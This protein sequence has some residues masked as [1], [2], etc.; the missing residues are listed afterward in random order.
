MVEECAVNE[1]GR[2]MCGA[3]RVLD[4]RA[5]I[6]E[7]A[8]DVVQK[9]RILDISSEIPN[10]TMSFAPDFPEA[11]KT[12]VTDGVKF[13]VGTEA[14]AETFCNENFYDWTAAGPIADENFD[15]V[16]LLMAAQGITLEN[17]GE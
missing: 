10:D 2:L 11:L 9:V 7:E 3:Y 12:A 16:R 14:C 4:A 13:Y 8:P 5:S 17:I 15:G 1:K 6:R